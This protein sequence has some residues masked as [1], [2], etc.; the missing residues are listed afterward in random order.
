[1]SELFGRSGKRPTVACDATI[2]TKLDGILHFLA[3]E[4]GQEPYKGQ[5]ALPGGFMEWEETCEQCVA[6]ELEEE[7]GLR[8]LDLLQIGAYSD[9]GRDPRGTI[10]S[11][12]YMGVLDTA[13]VELRAGDDAAKAMWI[14][15]EGHS[16]LAFD[17]ELILE[18]ALERL[19][20]RG[21]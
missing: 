19:N 9:L 1:M 5:F 10:V 18:K 12:S 14:A 13:D 7:T 20:E 16:P 11:V 2:F 3:V 4:R 6:R 8:G 17:H 15:V 21:F